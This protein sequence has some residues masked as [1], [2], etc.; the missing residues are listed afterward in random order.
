M[1]CIV[2]ALEETEFKPRKRW[3]GF[4]ANGRR[5]LMR[6]S[7]CMLVADKGSILYTWHE[8]KTDK[9]GVEFA[10]RHLLKSQQPTENKN[11]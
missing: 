4:V 8:T 2:Q 11:P 3:W 7:H 10:I 1:T 6:Y 9:L 5:Y